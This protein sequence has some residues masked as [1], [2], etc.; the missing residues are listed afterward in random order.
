MNLNPEEKKKLLS[1]K[2]HK[3][4]YFYQNDKGTFSSD[5]IDQSAKE[6]DTI[7]ML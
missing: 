2:E 6:Q 7:K 4:L 3:I 5:L 1:T